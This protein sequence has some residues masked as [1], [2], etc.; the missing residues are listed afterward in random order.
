MISVII[1]CYNQ[2][3]YIQEAIDSVKAQTYT[4]WEIL[5]V[6]DGS[7]D[8]ETVAFLKS[9]KEE[10]IA[11]YFQHNLGV[12][13]ARN[14]GVQYSIGDYLLFLDGDDKIANNYFKTAINEFNS[15]ADLSYVYGDIQ[16]FEETNKYRNLEQLDLRKTLIHNQTNVTGIMKK[17][18][19][20]ESKGFDPL[21]IKGWEDWD[22][23]IRILMLGFKFYK[24]PEAMIFYRIRNNSRDKIAIKLHEN[25]LLN[26]IFLKHLDLYLK[27]FDTPIF[28]LRNDIKQK[29][30][31]EQFNQR[32]Q[33]IYKTY[34]YR[35]GSFLLT[36]F[37]FFKKHFFRLNE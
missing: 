37:K 33:D 15:N 11:I 9:I 1:P 17:S 35:I 8:K 6:D 21:F 19:W 27:C 32:V 12:S 18:L 13:V 22:F 2:G 16:E 5:I 24:I 29:R 23:M 7:D 4:E 30:E 31:I 3:A 26:Q 10:K 28:L 36:P 34:S 14:V 20:I 25:F